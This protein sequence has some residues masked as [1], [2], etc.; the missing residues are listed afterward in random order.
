[1]RHENKAL[2]EIKGKKREMEKSN[3]KRKRR[4]DMR[5]RKTM[6]KTSKEE[7]EEERKGYEIQL[8]VV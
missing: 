4:I 3:R 2:I 8:S 5:R 7:G 6:E 1:M